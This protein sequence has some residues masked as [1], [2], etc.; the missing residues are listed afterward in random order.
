MTAYLLNAL[1]LI[2]PILL[3]NW[4]FASKLP[5]PFQAELFEKDIPVFIVQGENI[6]RLMVL[7]LPMCMPLSIVTQYQKFGLTLYLAGL[8][9]YF[10][11]W[12][13]QMIFPGSKWSKSAPGFL[14]PAYTPLIW[15][16]GIGLIGSSLYFP[17]PY[18]S[19]MYI[20]AAV[21]FCG[22]HVTHTLI[23]YKRIQDSFEAIRHEG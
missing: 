15:L 22:F 7:I 16:S 6:F 8:G 19:W 18:Q 17:S 12:A 10:L 2:L 4:V 11:A 1:L 14:A 13:A 20:L 23:V 21:I 5:Q 3:W 9:L